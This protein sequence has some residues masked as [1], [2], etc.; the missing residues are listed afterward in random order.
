VICTVQPLPE[1]KTGENTGRISLS[2]SF[3][4][5]FQVECMHKILLSASLTL[6]LFLPLHSAFGQAAHAVEKETG[7]AHAGEEVFQQR[8]MPCHSTV[9]NEVRVG[10]SLYHVTKGPHPRKTPTG[11]R[12]MI[13]N[14]K[15]KMPP[16]KDVLTKQDTDNLI[17]YVRSL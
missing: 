7:N 14:G 3:T 2:K 16:F 5:P 9:E 12:E 1:Q 13:E 8:C 4:N 10:P 17:A 11:V 6:A 15:G